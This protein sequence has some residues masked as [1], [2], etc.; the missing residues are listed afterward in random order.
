[1]TRGMIRTTASVISL[2]TALERRTRFELAAAES[3]IDWTFFPAF[4][5]D[6]SPLKYDERTSIRRFGRPL[7]SGEIG[8]YAS[9]YK[10][11]ESFLDSSCDQCVFLEDDAIVDWPVLNAIAKS[12]FTS[13]GIDILRMFATHAFPSK[14]AVPR[15]F[16]AH[17]HLLLCTGWTLGLQGYLLTRRGAEALL[18]TGTTITEPI[19]WAMSRYWKYRIRNYCLFP[20]PILERYVPSTIGSSRESA[21]ETRSGDKLHRLTWRIKERV[22]R[23]YVNR[24]TFRANQFGR[25]VDRGVSFLEKGTG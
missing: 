16:S 12:D 22:I 24:V 14:I 4:R 17:S 19:D 7:S 5:G 2:D 9:H 15:F 3:A 18:A 13:I 23:E 21:F 6:N 1:M 10:A 20:F 8:A 25:H 11:W